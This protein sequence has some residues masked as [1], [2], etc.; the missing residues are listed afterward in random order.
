M[1]N[2]IKKPSILI[3]QDMLYFL[4]IHYNLIY[5]SISFSK[6]IKMFEFAM[7]QYFEEMLYTH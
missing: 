1:Q 3:Q 7:A 5:N 4:D 2:K 6:K